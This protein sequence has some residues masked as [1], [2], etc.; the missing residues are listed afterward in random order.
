MKP[1]AKPAIQPGWVV[2]VRGATSVAYS[3][4]Q[5]RALATHHPKTWTD[6]SVTPN[7]VY[8]G[9]PLWRLVA[10]ADGGSAATLNLDWLGLGYNV[11]VS[12]MG[13]DALG[14]DAPTTA[15]FASSAI[16]G[17][18]QRR[19]RRPP[20]R[21]AAHPDPGRH[22]PQAGPSYLWQPTWPARL[23]GTGVAADQSF[24]GVVRVVLHKPVVP[25]YLTPLVL[26][27]RRTAKIAYLDF[28]TTSTWDGPRSSTCCPKNKR[29]TAA[30][31]S[32]R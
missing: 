14:A 8:A 1:P 15:T 18:E 12:G 7:V 13:V 24:G 9:T 17:S 6:T 16:A 25:S 22:R 20:G 2:Q 32:T 28:P 3:A 11:D 30:R 29:S 21:Q 27:G 23:V 5:F 26:K 31:R 10:L 4:A 19:H